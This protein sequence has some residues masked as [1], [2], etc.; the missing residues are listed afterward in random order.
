MDVVASMSNDSR[1]MLWIDDTSGGQTIS[2]I[3]GC[4]IGSFDFKTDPY[5]P[6]SVYV[7]AGNF[8]A[9]NDKYNRT[10]LYTIMTVEGDDELDVHCE[11]IGLDLINEM[12]NAWNFETDQ[13]LD[14]YLN[15]VF[16][17]SSWKVVYEAS[18]LSTQ[19]RHLKFD[20]NT[21]TK[22][23]RLESIMSGFGFEGDFQIT[24]EYMSV[25]TMEFHVY[26][27]LSNKTEYDISKIY[28]DSINLISLNRSESIDDLYTAVLPT[29]GQVAGKALDI[30]S[31]EY[32]DGQFWTTKGD[33]KLYDRLAAQKWSRFAGTS[34]QDKTKDPAY[35]Y[36]HYSSNTTAVGTLFDEA[37]ANLKE[38]HDVKLAYEAKLLDLDS[39]LGDWIKIVDHAK[40]QDVYLKARIQE[41]T[42]HYTV[43][44]EDE[45]KLANYK[46]LSTA[47]GD[48]IRN[49]LNQIQEK[50]S[51]VTV[52]DL[53]FTISDQGS[54]APINAEWSVN[55]PDIPEGK[56]LWIKTVDKYSD[57]TERV[58]Y[59]V[60]KNK[61]DYHGPATVVS[62]VTV[63]FLSTS[64]YS[65]LKEDGSAPEKSDWTTEQPAYKD[66]RY[67]WKREIVTWSDGT[68]DYTFET[69][70]QQMTEAYKKLADANK[71]ILNIQDQVDGLIESWSADPVPTL[72]NYPANEWA[73]DTVK[74]NHIGDLYYDK[75]NKCYRFMQN[76][77]GSFVWKLIADTDVTKA[78]ADAQK[79]LDA[80]DQSVT[81]LT[82]EYYAS[83]SA[84]ELEG[85]SW[86]EDRPAWTE[87]NY[88]W[89]RTKTTTKAGIITYS[90]PSCIQGNSGT[91][92]KDGISPTVNI[93]KTDGS[94]TITI[95]D[96]NGI[97]SQVVKDGINGTPG[98]TGADGKTS[99]FHVKYSNDGGKT[100]TPNNGEEVGTYIG[101]YSDFKIEDSTSVSAYTWAK[102]KGEQGE[103]GLQG[104]RGEQGIPG[105]DGSNGANGKTSYFHIKYS[106][107]ANPTSSSQM[108]ET[109]NIYIGTYV[110]YVEADSSDPS[111]YTWSRFQ[112]VQGDKGEKGIPGIDGTNGKT[113]YL[114]IA[115]ADSA[116]GKTGFDVSNSTNKL[117]IGQYTD[118][119]PTDSTDHTKYS[120]TKIKG[121]KGDT[122]AKGETGTTGNLWVNPAFDADKPQ[123]TSI[124][125]GVKA[126]N[127]SNVNICKARDHYNDD[128]AF[129]VM[130]RHKYRIV[131]H[132]KKIQGAKDL[133]AGIWYTQQ[134]SGNPW[135]SYVSRIKVTAL[136][137]GW[138]EAIY[139]FICP[140]SKSKGCVFLQI[141]QG[142][143]EENPTIWYVSNLMCIDITGLQGANGQNGSPGRGVKSTE[144]TYQ[145]WS[146][147]T[148]T[149]NGTWSTS[150]PD[151]TAD[152]PYL[153]TRT[154]I[155]YTDN[156]KSTSYS[157]GST[158]KGVNVGGRNLAKWTSTGEHWEKTSF[159]KN[160]R[161]FTRENTG[162]DENYIGLYNK[163]SLLPSN[164]YTLSATI[165]SNGNV[166]SCDMFVY[167]EQITSVMQK[168]ISGSE[169]TTNPQRFELLFTVPND[170]TGWDSATIRFDNNGTTS[171]GT[172][173]I[174][175]V[176]D[177]KLELGNIA[178]DW[179]PAPEDVDEG[180]NNA[181]SSADKA[182]TNASNA[183]Q[184]ANSAN[185]NASTAKKDAANA[186]A[187][188]QQAGDLANTAKADAAAANTAIL[189]ALKQIAE[190][191]ANSN[192]A[193]KLASD[194]WNGISPIAQVVK[195]DTQGLKVLNSKDSTNYAQMQDVGFFIFVSNNQVAEFGINSKMRNMAIQDYL[196]FGSH[197]AET[198][199]IKEE[200]STAFYWIGDVK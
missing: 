147:G 6:D 123:I 75:S 65:A 35:I 95:T 11:D 132:R 105:K 122:G 96:K 90:N 196:M 34:A 5:L 193:K 99:Y 61:I 100:F 116:D 25:K 47:N 142:S 69:Y 41:V 48:T 173:A 82:T 115:Y 151:T 29:G 200:E 189:T 28:I 198:T 175:Y 161:T 66:G 154:V 177:V 126:P 23:S 76:G 133:Y 181:Q 33:N 146:N 143:A 36:G 157:V 9:F 110:D 124:V 163:T 184:S 10:R 120:W 138:E 170:S 64:Q 22:L 3:N 45:G 51:K 111:K 49:L 81:S 180:I 102:I 12:A 165:W 56:F 178:T 52:S 117:Y 59:T 108:T 46:L 54:Y 98:A 27:T 166:V 113:S 152:K 183:Q 156:T 32:D 57:G 91:N 149:P 139:E 19:T 80:T 24:M 15:Q 43:S 127:G 187:S 106:S 186:N 4:A 118:F 169:L 125:N 2:L 84:T 131:M 188:A 197:R 121:D 195:A 179:T 93:S 58:T 144:V 174:L 30:S 17:N 16:G 162:T 134:T 74:K 50:V 37:L 85:G 167:N 155:T 72:T 109:P 168:A 191:Q 129:A 88:I 150:V 26:K 63:Y 20:N 107:V 190:I 103:R 153:W 176:K 194:A 31:V 42:N 70:D 38:H 171:E 39:D 182:N 104:I 94:T 199:I 101:T 78:I 60:T 172:T 62:R 145:I 136:T 158:L 71:D 1:E 92:G 40:Q 55:Q 114:H 159:D 89:S 67:F 135:D 53:Y 119:N 148:S 128:T 137:D 73:T 130:P 79:A 141:D 7:K 77:D 13:T 97:H 18:G 83:T 192:E 44:G 21:D 140:D 68:V 14:F 185:A 164:T 87:T 160:T 8:I 112:G 86:S